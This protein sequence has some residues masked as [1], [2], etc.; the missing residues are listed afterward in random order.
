[1]GTSMQSLKSIIKPPLHSQ[2]SLA[3]PNFLPR[4]FDLNTSHQAHVWGGKTYNIEP[5]THIFT[6]IQEHFGNRLIKSI[7]LPKD[8]VVVD[9]G[10][11]IGE[12]LWQLR[13]DRPYLGIGVDIALPSLK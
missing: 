2:L 10:C 13:Q 7:T 5:R 9:I 1:M 3:I 8:A 11:F 12:K 6:T 4:R